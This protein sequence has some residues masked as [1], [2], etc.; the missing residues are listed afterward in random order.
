VFLVDS[1]GRPAY[2]AQS[3][4]LYKQMLVG[5]FERVF[6]VGPVFWA[7]PHD[8]VRHI[9]EYVS[10]DAELGS[11]A[12]IATCSRSSAGRT[13]STCCSAGWS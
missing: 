7:E 1:F 10:L 12:T 8:T 5:V 3:P 13:P 9:A 11:S 4:Q 2:L 6:E